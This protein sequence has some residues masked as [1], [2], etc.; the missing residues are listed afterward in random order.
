MVRTV[1]IAKIENKVLISGNTG[2]G[3]VS[4]IVLTGAGSSIGDVEIVNNKGA[5]L[6][7]SGFT[8]TRVFICALFLL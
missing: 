4:G 6:A 8:G 3:D 5:P 1:G 2:L 7:V